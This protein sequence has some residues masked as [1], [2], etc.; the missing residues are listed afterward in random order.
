MRTM[1][2]GRARALS[3]LLITAVVAAAMAAC[4]SRSGQ[5]RGGQAAMVRI[6][7]SYVKLVLAMGVHDSS[8]VDAYYGPAGWRTSVE[9]ERQ[10]PAQI[11]AGA[12]RLMAD[13]RAAPGSGDQ[14]EA[15]RRRFL[16]EQLTALL[17]RLDLLGGKRLRFDDES[18]VLYDAVAPVVPESRFDTVLAR[19]DRLI[20]GAG[21]LNSRIDQMRSALVIPPDRLDAVFAAAIAEC[22]ARTVR[23]IELPESESFTVEYV[24]DKPWGGYNWYQGN[25]RSI[26]QV[27]LDLPVHIDRAIDLACHE[28]YPGHHLQNI[29]LEQ[30]LVRGRGWTEFSVVPLYGPMSLIG[31]GSS[32]YGIEL[33][34]PLEERVEFERRVLYPLAG[35]DPA[36]AAIYAQVNQLLLEL[37]HA[38]NQA[39]R[40]YIDGEID[41]DAVAAYLTRYALARPEF[42]RKMVAFIEANRS[43]VINYNL[44]RDLVRAWIE[45]QGRGDRRW[46][47]FERLVSSPMTASDLAR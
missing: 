13:I 35:L 29:L 12:E 22:R 45:K 18:R 8:Y 9:R 1:S 37:Q 26:I 23:H 16:I 25:Y 27:N 11:R 15:L 42:A 36:R 7:E 30:R 32:N 34:F 14:L 17:A 41:A 19:I 33:A 6:S 39:A 43:Y 38:T 31:E 21:S 40:R 20:P 44:G 46:A 47:A 2:H 24:K 5:G 3:Y 4:Q 10:P 28:G